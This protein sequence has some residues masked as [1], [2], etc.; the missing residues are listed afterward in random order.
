MNKK[1]KEFFNRNLKVCRKFFL[2]MLLKVKTKMNL[3][4]SRN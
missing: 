2:T 1:R 3:K 4:R